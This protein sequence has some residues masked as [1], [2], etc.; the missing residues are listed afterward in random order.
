MK[1]FGGPFGQSSIAPLIEHYLKVEK[2]AKLLPD[3]LSTY[4]RGNYATAREIAKKIAVFEEEADTIKDETRRHISSSIF[5]AVE[6]ADILLYL[7]TQDD[8]ADHYNSIV[9]LISLRRTTI[10]PELE[11]AMVILADR[12]IDVVVELGKMLM[13]ASGRSP[14][15][16][17]DDFMVVIPQL[18]HAASVVLEGFIQ[19]VFEH[20]SELDPVSVMLLLRFGEEILDMA[21]CARNTCDILRRLLS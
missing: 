5:A 21:K 1:L 20:E 17:A 19:Q 11:K 16:A 3:F 7:S 15:K 18:E 14:G 8:I 6:R 13:A 2:G 9:N 10:G 12:S 4:C